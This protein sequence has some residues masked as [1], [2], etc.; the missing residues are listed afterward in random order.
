[1]S[2]HDRS[3][4]RILGRDH[5]GFTL[6]EVLV[7]LVLLGVLVALLLPAV[8]AAREQARRAA[9][10]NNLKQVGL[11]LGS[12]TTRHGGL[13]PGYVS[14]WD[15]FLMREFGPGWGWASMI[16]PE[17]EQLPLFQ[18]INY[19]V[20]ISDPGQSTIRGAVPAIFLCP[21]DNMPR[22]WTAEQGEVWYFAGQMHYAQNPIC[23]VP[24]SN[25]VGVFGIG[26]PGVDGDG[27]FFRNSFI[28]PLDISDGLSSTL[29]VG[30]RSINLNNGRGQATWVGAVTG[31]VFWSCAPNVGDPDAG[32]GCWKEDGSGMVLGHTGEGHGP[33]DPWGDANQFLSRHGHGAHFLFCDGHVR[34]LDASINYAVYKAMSTRATGEVFSNSY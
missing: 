6:I 34:Y 27:V 20:L 28:R 24:G 16:L 8:E 17:L 5:H 32:G 21:S 25:Y 29:C 14:T 2:A 19:Q 33:G 4:R 3:A 9:C 30:E 18:G 12:Y 31:A 7:V 11:A 26:E 15:D 10:I 22:S 23:D 1:M 13:P